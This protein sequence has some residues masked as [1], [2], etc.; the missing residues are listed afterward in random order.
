M[1]DAQKLPPKGDLDGLGRL[2]SV[3]VRDRNFLLPKEAPRK[4]FR[5]WLTP[6]PAL[7]QGAS[8]HCVAYAGGKYLLAHPI[9]NKMPNLQQLYQDCQRNDEWDGEDYDGTSVRALMKMLKGQGLISEYRWAFDIDTLVGSLINL[10]PVVVGTTWTMDM[11]MPDRHE[12]IYPSGREVGGHAYMLVAAN[13]RRKNPD[14]TTG[15]VRMINSW[16][17]RWGKNGRAWITLDGMA[18][19]LKDWGEAAMAT[20]VKGGLA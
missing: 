12:Y 16:G 18:T 13:T 8:S 10:G 2:T 17:P 20:E 19:L 11:F 3:D 14:G 5:S 15:A 4:W 1:N 6:G 7:D 9:V